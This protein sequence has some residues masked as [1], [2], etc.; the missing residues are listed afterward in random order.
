MLSF[1]VSARGLRAIT[2]TI[3]PSLAILSSAAVAHASVTVTFDP[4]TPVQGKPIRV[5]LTN[6]G[7]GT[8]VLPTH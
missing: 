4:P 7:P 3:L 6:H 8:I 1:I 2:R 5:T